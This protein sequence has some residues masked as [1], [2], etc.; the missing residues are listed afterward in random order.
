MT[1]SIVPVAIFVLLLAL[2]PLALRWVRR[3]SRGIPGSTATQSRVVSAVAVGPNQRIVTVEVGPEGGK[4]WLVLG[5]TAQSITCVHCMAA[6]LPPEQ[7]RG[8]PAGSAASAA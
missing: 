4:S 1:Q 3:R 7:D 5:V 6:P 2:V 8:V